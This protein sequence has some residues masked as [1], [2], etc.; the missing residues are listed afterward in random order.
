MGFFDKILGNKP[1]TNVKSE[2]QSNIPYNTIMKDVDPRKKTVLAILVVSESVFAESD[3]ARFLQKIIDREQASDT[4]IAPNLYVKF[5][6]A[7]DS[8]DNNDYMRSVVI[9]HLAPLM[10][11]IE[12]ADDLNGLFERTGV[13][14]F[15]KPIIAL[16]PAAPF[17]GKLFV[18]YNVK[19]I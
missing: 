12:K 11:K 1:K 4:A 13:Q 5:Y 19:I 17:R 18:M 6:T 7:S 9:S 10:P 8:I 14:P 2:K 15:E 3:R 16:A